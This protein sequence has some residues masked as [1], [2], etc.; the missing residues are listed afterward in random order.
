MDINI[1]DWSESEEDL[2]NEEFNRYA[3]AVCKRVNRSLLYDGCLSKE[4][5]DLEKLYK[6][7]L[8]EKF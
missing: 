8:I 6:L 2:Q 4:E 3:D 7:K 1:K 5:Q